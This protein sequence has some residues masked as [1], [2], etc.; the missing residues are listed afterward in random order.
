MKEVIGDLLETNCKVIAHQVNCI[1]VMGSG[2]AKCIKNRWP[3]VFTG[4]LN[5]IHTLDHECL[6]GCLILEAEPGKYIANLFGQY[7]YNGYYKNKEDYYKHPYYKRPDTN[8]SGDLR[9]TNYEAL[10]S[11]LNY[12]RTR[13]I[14]N[15]VDSVSFPYKL[16]SDRGGGNWN[17]VKIMISE[18]FKDTDIIVEIRKKED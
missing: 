2:V 4:Y 14:E 7:F 17:I 13:M 10:F 18:I 8:L 11:S 12:L 3:E 16:G 6:G 5:T 9:F 1:G 15:K